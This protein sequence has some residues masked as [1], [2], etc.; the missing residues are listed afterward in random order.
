MTHLEKAKEDVEKLRQ[1]FDST[2][3]KSKRKLIWR[4]K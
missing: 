1:E 3:D 2:S 4:S